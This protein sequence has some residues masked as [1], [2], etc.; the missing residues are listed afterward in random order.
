MLTLKR[1]IQNVDSVVVVDNKALDRIVGEKLRIPN[2]TFAETNS[3][4]CWPTSSVSSIYQS[5]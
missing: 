1:L 4:V 5:R 2:P 3:L